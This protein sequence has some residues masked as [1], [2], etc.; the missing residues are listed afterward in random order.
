MKKELKERKITKEE[1]GFI[2]GILA[3][4]AKILEIVYNLL[5]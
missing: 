1:I 5:M 2:F 3:S 4:A